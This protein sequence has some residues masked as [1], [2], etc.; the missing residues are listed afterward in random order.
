MEVSIMRETTE[1][2]ILIQKILDDMKTK[3]FSSQTIRN[4]CVAFNR[5]KRLADEK[6]YDC[7]TE[8]LF[9][10]F[11]NDNNIR[12]GEFRK[13]KERFN[14]CCVKL[15]RSSFE[16]GNPDWSRQQSKDV[17]SLVT[18]PHF[19]YLLETFIDRLNLEGFAPN[20][21]SGYKRIVAYFLVFCQEKGY[22]GLDSLQTNDLTNFIISLYQKGC[23]NLNSASNLAQ[24]T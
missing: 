24:H 23:F 18:E 13:T 11:L 16:T 10:V 4:Y 6:G 14:K 15:L 8:E 17:A 20:T 1:L 9:T 2:G 22:I 21:V 3:K 5:F 7:P 19:Y 12:T